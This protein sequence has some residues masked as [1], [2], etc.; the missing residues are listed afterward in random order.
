MT[1]LCHDTPHPQH[2]LL[3]L[4]YHTTP[5]P[6]RTSHP[7]LSHQVFGLL[8]FI[9]PNIL[10]MHYRQLILASWFI[11]LHATQSGEMLTIMETMC[12]KIY[13]RKKE[14]GHAY[15]GSTNYVYVWDWNATNS[16]YILPVDLRGRGMITDIKTW[17]PFPHLWSRSQ[18]MYCKVLVFL[19]T[20]SSIL[21]ALFSETCI[22]NLHDT[23]CQHMKEVCVCICVCVCVSVYV[24][25]YLCMCGGGGG[26]GR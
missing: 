21:H 11:V 25:V 15:N 18:W 24:C 20:C 10:H 22:A 7:S 19:S 23:F 26:G 16:V 9:L 4:L 1:A 12:I 5:T 8:S 17:Q 3:F 2:T 6:T 14:I 13:R